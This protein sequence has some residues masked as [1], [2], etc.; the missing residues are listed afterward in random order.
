MPYFYKRYWKNN[1]RRR[2]RKR[3][4]RPYWRR[5]RK[6]FRSTRR[7]RVRRKFNRK[8]RKRKLKKLKINQWQPTLIRRCKITG[9]FTLFQATWD[10]AYNNFAQYQT[11]IVPEK[12]PG[13]GGWGTYVFNLGAFYQMFKKVR[14]WWTVS[15]VGMPLCRYLGCRMT[16]YR[17]DFIDYIVTYDLDY[18]MTDSDL[19]HASSQPYRMMLRKRKIVVTCKNN[20]THK[21][22]YKR[23]KIKPPKQL[24]NRWFFQREFT[25]TNLVLLT[26][27]AA[28]L[29]TISCHPNEPS[30]NLSFET[31]NPHIFKN[32]NFNNYSQTSGY[33]PQPGRF[34]YGTL[35]FEP[36]NETDMPTYGDL[37]FLGNTNV[38]TEGK[39]LNDLTNTQDFLKSENWGNPLHP[40]YLN[41]T[42]LMWVSQQQ[43]SYFSN[44]TKS[45]K[46]KSTELTQ[47]SE[48]PLINCRYSPD[49]DT[50]YNTECYFL[51]NFNANNYKWDAPTN[52]QLTF[53]GF[54]LWNLLWGWPDWQKKLALISQI[55]QHYVLVLKSPHIK[56]QLPFYMPLSSSFINGH[57][58]YDT[59]TQP[60]ISDKLSWHP[61]FL[62]QQDIINKICLTGP[63]TVKPVSKTFQ[64]HMKY[65]F[66]FKW[67]GSPSDMET[68]ADPSKQ[69]Q[70]PVPHNIS[71]PIQIQDP[72]YDPRLYTYSWDSRR[73]LLTKTAIDRISKDY[74]TERSLFNITDNQFNP[75]APQ[76][77]Y[78]KTLQTLLQTWP[79]QKDQETMQELIIKFQ[80]QQQQLRDNLQ[81]LL[82]QRI[83]T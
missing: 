22:P 7:N 62:Y 82:R 13:G 24:I 5:T 29:T 58:I 42:N 46:V 1:Y 45:E 73:D 3:Y 19:R 59:E 18:P 48:P 28:S 38:M 2:F 34:L 12:E 56:P 15:N 83:N 31:L 44:K 26:A 70:Y 75:P 51:S 40:H 80:Q 69:P 54:P 63:C 20:N 78:E 81:Q 43:P 74:A 23:V 64:A 33:T 52:E 72:N 50:G 27:S 39:Q 9:L 35:H 41:L 30:N 47:M 65:D 79:E 55:D 60:P 76:K 37:I 4:R 67:G 71:A 17:D 8:Y 68:I 66:Y 21:K 36:T 32:L 25:N 16:F 57:H 11:S 14:N 6:A 10:R 77:D 61:K 49:T 53:S